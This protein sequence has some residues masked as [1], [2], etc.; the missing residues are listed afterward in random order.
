MRLEWQIKI[1]KE[2]N[3]KK[4]SQIGN[5]MIQLEKTNQETL[6]KEDSMVPGQSQAIQTKLSEITKEI[7]QTIK[8][9]SAAECKQKN[10]CRSKIWKWKEH[11]RNA[12]WI[13]NMKKELDIYE[14]SA[15]NI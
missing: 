4:S 1:P 13:N 8:D 10:A 15:A 12:E 11:N 3:G 5:L 9:K 6:D 2:P 14:G 7:L